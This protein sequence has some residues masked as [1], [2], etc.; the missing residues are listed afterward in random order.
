MSERIVGHQ[1]R[2]DQKA[3]ESRC[4]N[5]CRTNRYV[6]RDIDRNHSHIAAAVHHATPMDWLAALSRALEHC[7][8]NSGAFHWISPDSK[9]FSSIWPS[10]PDRL[11]FL[12]W[13]RQF[14]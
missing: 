12:Y 7:N 5:E 4:S 13:N 6:W 1:Q 14:E 11:D 8:R 9:A 10:F 3:H 2:R